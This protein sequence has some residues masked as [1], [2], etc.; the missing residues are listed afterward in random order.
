MDEIKEN[1]KKQR[2][3]MP[4]KDFGKGEEIMGQQSKPQAVIVSC[5]NTIFRLFI[6]L[7]TKLKHERVSPIGVDLNVHYLYLVVDILYCI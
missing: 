7:K 5:L 6:V 4:K 3:A 2:I 1:T